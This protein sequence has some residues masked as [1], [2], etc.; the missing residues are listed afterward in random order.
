M[1][2]LHVTEIVRG[3]VST[4]IRINMLG[5][6]KILGD[7]CLSA[8]VSE[9]EALDLAPVPASQ[10]EVFKQTGRNIKS[11]FSLAVA[12][13]KKTRR[14]KPDIIHIHSSFAGL[15]CR[16]TFI[17]IKLT[18]PTYK[19]VI[20]YC[21]HA[22][23]FLMEGAEW[24]KKIY[25]F[26]EILLQPLTDAIICVS[27]YERDAAIKF[28]LSPKKLK[29][30]YNGIY[31]PEILERDAVN[32]KT[33]GVMQLLFLGRLDFQKGF[34]LMLQVMEALE[35]EDFHLTV[36]GKALQSDHEPPQRSNITYA[37]WIDTDKIGHYI[38]GSDVLVMPSRWE[39]FGLAA[40]EA[41]AN[42]CPSLA[43]DNCSLPEIVLNKVTGKLFSTGNVFEMVSILRETSK[44][45]W[46]VLGR[47]ARK[48]VA[49]KFSD[50]KMSRETIHLYRE[51]ISFSS[52]SALKADTIPK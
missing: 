16:F 38:N 47:A 35:D 18:T 52:G 3:G 14:E 36:V 40:A 48:H 37:G 2:I 13:F 39:S 11:F 9:E 21:P 45:E 19:P 23:G 51:L 50:K 25:A 12:F 7:D 17:L 31:I 28:G 29:V 22:F 20:L 5:Q 26:A 42:G 32:L 4:I 49:C 27:N 43:S 1:K 30:I 10:I 46:A 33:D 15:L 34:D 8:L 44:E 41:A 6:A 24:K